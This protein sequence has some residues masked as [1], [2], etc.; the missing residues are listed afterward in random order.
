MCKF[1]NA[2]F[3]KSMENE[4]QFCFNT[5]YASVPVMVSANPSAVGQ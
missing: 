2:D 4:G 3:D 1:Q 5:P